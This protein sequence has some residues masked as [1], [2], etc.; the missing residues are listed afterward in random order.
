M[1]LTFRQIGEIDG[2]PLPHTAFTF[3]SWWY[4]R[5]DYNSIAEAWLTEGFYLEK[6]DMKKQK[7]TL[8]R[9]E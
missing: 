2:A 7:I 5:K 8:R 3:T 6:L 4:P 1:T 9:E